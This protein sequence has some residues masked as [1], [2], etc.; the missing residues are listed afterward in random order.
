MSYSWREDFSQST[1]G[2]GD[3]ITIALAELLASAARLVAL[4]HVPHH[5]VECMQ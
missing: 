4:M 2:T 3:G 1:S 5:L